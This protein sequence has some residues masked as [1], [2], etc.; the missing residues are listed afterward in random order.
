MLESLDDSMLAEVLGVEV[1]LRDRAY[2]A[3]AVRLLD[4]LSVP[5]AQLAELVDDDAEDDVEE[6][7][8]HDDE[9]GDVEDI[10][11]QEEL[12]VRAVADLRLVLEL[13]VEVL[14]DATATHQAVVQDGCEAERERLAVVAPVLLVDELALELEE[15]EG[16]EDVDR[17]HAHEERP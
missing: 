1:L 8:E 17:E 4:V 16:G 13:V 6:E 10:P 9:E 12:R 3:V 15:A 7:H 5:V 2:E 14:G 11:R